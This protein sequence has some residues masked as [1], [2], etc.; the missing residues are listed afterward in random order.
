M[1]FCRRLWGGGRRWADYDSILCWESEMGLLVILC[2]RESCLNMVSGLAFR[3][4]I[5]MSF[6]VFYN[7]EIAKGSCFPCGCETQTFPW[8]HT[9]LHGHRH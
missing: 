6:T 8:N 9:P 2:V 5:Y 7:K 3:L 1:R 4:G